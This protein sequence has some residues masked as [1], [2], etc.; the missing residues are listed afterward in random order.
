MKD[1]NCIFCK[2]ASGEIPSNTIYED[3]MFRVILDNGPATRG[4]ALVLPKEHY[5][6]LYEISD[7]TVASAMIVA[8]KMALI[9]K[10]KLH[11]E[12]LNL[13]QNNGERAGQTVRHFHIHLIPRYENDE[14]HILWNPKKP[15]VQELQEVRD[16]LNI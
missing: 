2:I 3:D 1:E 14:Q 7:D 5:A 8:K 6:D 12:G 13:I 4:H 15:T 10:K 9:M 11:C 16:E